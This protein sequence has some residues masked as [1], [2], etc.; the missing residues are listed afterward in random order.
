MVNEGPDTYFTDPDKQ[1][2]Y[3]NL[4]FPGGSRGDARRVI[5]AYQATFGGN[6]A[7]QLLVWAL[8]AHLKAFLG[9]WPHC[10]IQAD[11]GAGKS[12]LIKRLE[13]TIAFQMLSGQSLQTEFRLLTSISGT[14]HPIGWEEL[15]A[16]RQDTIDKAVGLLQESYQYTVTRRGSDMTEFVLSAPVLLAGED[17]PVNGLLGKIVRVSL[18]HKGELLPDDLPR[19]PVRQWLQY[20]AGY[21][22]AELR[23]K[24]RAVHTRML[25]RCM[26]PGDPGASRMVEN[27]SAVALAWLLLC[28]FAD[29]P[30]NQAAFPGDLREVM[31]DHIRETKPD[32]QPWVWIMDTAISEM[33]SGG[34]HHPYLIDGVE[35]DA[36]QLQPCLLVRPNHI[37]DHLA[38]TPALREKFNG[39][40]VKSAKVF[41][42][43]LDQAGVVL[44][45]GLERSI[46]RSRVAHLTAISIE[47]LAQYGLHVTVPEPGEGY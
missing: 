21:G 25:A 4:T 24:Y 5:Q 38:H 26:A 18:A 8:G 2:P 44:R 3:W 27:Y 47:A 34:F 16:R 36:K 40:P 41:S 29:L 6:A 9:F 28:D 12:T 10:M 13:R 14:S 31:N 46:R 7:A 37:I 39:L 17:V 23:E 15:S 1:C 22:A 43:Q 11:K 42:R 19:F 32:R 45:K 35:D 30:E 20:L 33:S